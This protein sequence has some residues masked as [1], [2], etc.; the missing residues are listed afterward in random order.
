MG[1]TS[2]DAVPV[3][4]YSCPKCG[5]YGQ[6]DWDEPIAMGEEICQV[7]RGT[8]LVSKH[9][10]EVYVRFHPASE[11]RP[12]RTEG[13]WVHQ[14]LERIKDTS[15]WPIHPALPVKRVSRPPNPIAP[16]ELGVI[17]ADEVDTGGTITVY[18]VGSKKTC[19]PGQ[20]REARK[21]AIF[22]SISAM[23]AAGWI[24]D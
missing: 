3:Q 7:C 24:G 6:H 16:P 11:G 1:N 10:H 14:E 13:D 19:P 22:D 20:P 18:G 15:K 5:G 2:D 8:G 21:L 17:F 23:V 12:S 9:V 4:A